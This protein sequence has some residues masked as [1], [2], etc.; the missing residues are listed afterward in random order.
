MYFFGT[1]QHPQ[2][3]HMPQLGQFQL[4]G[5]GLVKKF[6]TIQQKM[7]QLWCSGCPAHSRLP[8]WLF[9]IRLVYWWKHDWPGGALKAL[10][11]P[12]LWEWWWST[13]KHLKSNLVASQWFSSLQLHA[14]FLLLHLSFVFVKMVE[15]FRSPHK[16]GS[17]FGCWEELGSSFSMSVEATHP[18]MLFHENKITFSGP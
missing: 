8:W 5:L 16:D 9:G 12:P 6:V 18:A 13:F 7:Q 1:V 2:W 11:F 4:V 3:L 15:T 10:L 17:C 14:P